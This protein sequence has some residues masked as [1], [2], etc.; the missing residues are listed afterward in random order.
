[1][2]NQSKVLSIAHRGSSG[3]APENTL[4]AFRLAVEQQADGIELDVHLSKDQQI[5]VCHDETV[6]RT[7]NGTGMIRD[8]NAEELK[9]LDAGSWFHPQFSTE[10]IPLLEEVFQLVPDHMIINIEIKNSDGGQILQHLSQHIKRYHR[11]NS[12]I[13][14][15]FDHRCLKELKLMDPTIRIGLLLAHQLVDLV[16]YVD[17]MGVEVYSIHPHHAIADPGEMRR[18]IEKGYKIFIYTIDQEAQFQKAMEAG[19]TG[20]ITNYP[21]RLIGYIHFIKD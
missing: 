19:I 21:Q 11:T 4:A 17:L 12:V 20:I 1:M 15:S 18:L 6:D 8:M 2:L 10:T 3:E 5:V 13:V 16:Q 14:S 9:K 7:T